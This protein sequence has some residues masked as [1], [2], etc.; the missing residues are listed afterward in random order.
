MDTQGRSD[1]SIMADRRWPPARCRST[2]G[3]ALSIRRSPPVWWARAARWTSSMSSSSESAMGSTCSF[4]PSARLTHT[5]VAA[6]DVDVLDVVL[7]EQQL[8]PAEAELAGH[9]PPD[10]LLLFLDRRGGDRPFHHGAGRLVDGLS[11]Q[12]LDERAALAFAHAGRPVADDAVGHVLGGELFE[13]PAL[14]VVHRPAPHFEPEVAP[15]SSTADAGRSES[16]A[17][18][19]RGVVDGRED[20]SAERRPLVGAPRPRRRC[21]PALSARHRTDGVDDPARRLGR[22][23]T[24]ATGSA[25]A[26]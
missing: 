17:G 25:R 5:R 18:R 19:V 9:Q 11:G 7:V 24:G 4:T 16:S 22:R 21:R 14:L 2:M 1:T 26:S 23:P 10:D 3:L 6:V 12:L 13:L 8:Q 20:G 15:A